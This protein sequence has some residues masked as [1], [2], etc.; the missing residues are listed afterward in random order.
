MRLVLFVVAFLPIL[1]ASAQ[2]GKTVEPPIPAFTVCEI[3]S[4]RVEFDGKQVRIRARLGA[5]DE[6]VWF[7]S[8]DCP[9][10]VTTDAH[11]WPSMIWMQIASPDMNPNDRARPVNFTSNYES[12]KRLRPKLLKIGRKVPEE[13]IIWTY[14]GL[15]ETRETYPKV[16]Y[17]KAPPVYIGFGHLGAAPAQLL[18]KTT[19]DVNVDPN[20]HPRNRG[21]K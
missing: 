14:T 2:T 4:Q 11:V 19:D 16:T 20:C 15:F 9:G 13:C 3:L 8:D 5:T 1:A 17:V 10:V 21:Q 18:W 7:E 6:G 12:E